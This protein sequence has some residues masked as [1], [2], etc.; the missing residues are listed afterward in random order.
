MNRRKFLVGAAGV[1]GLAGLTGSGFAQGGQAPAAPA[2]PGT[3]RQG[4]RGRG[5]PA[6]VP[7]EKLARIA[8]MTLNFNPYLK[9]ANGTP[10]PEQTMEVFDLPK[11][12]VEMYGIHNIEYQHTH[13]KSDT[14]LVHQG[15]EGAPRLDKVQMKINLEFARRN[16]AR[17]RA[18]PKASTHEHGSTSRPSTAAPA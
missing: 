14:T 3:G 12:Y 7:P 4:G 11:M 6:Q 8:L 1:A 2:A 10:T 13:R 18:A 17:C 16:F 15:S 5:G 9:P